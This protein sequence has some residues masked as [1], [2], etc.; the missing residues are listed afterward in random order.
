MKKLAVYRPVRSAWTTQVF[1]ANNACVKLQPNGRAVLPYKFISPVSAGVCPV[2][3]GSMYIAM[4]MLGHNGRDIATWNGEPVY[5][6]ADF[7]GT[8][9]QEV[10]SEGG[11]GIDVVSLTP[12]LEDENGVMQ[13][14]KMRYW[15]NKDLN[16]YAGDLVVPGELIAL[17]DNTGAS[18][19]SHIH[20]WPKWCNKDGEGI[21]QDNG[22]YGSVPDEFVD[23]KDIFMGDHLQIQEKQLQIIDQLKSI[24]HYLQML[25]QQ[26]LG[27]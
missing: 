27:R 2:G 26:K 16:N 20:F 10:D 11:I 17:S 21:K 23:Y 15:H 13:Y 4:G 18:S 8:V 25:I 19:G 9:R 5:H 7:N 6:C 22:Y 24:I 12:I 14:V 3:Y 1:G